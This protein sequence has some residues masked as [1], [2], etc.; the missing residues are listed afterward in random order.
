MVLGY[1]LDAHAPPLSYWWFCIFNKDYFENSSKLQV[2]S[3]KLY[4]SIKV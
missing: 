1:V 2:V 3:E 4:N